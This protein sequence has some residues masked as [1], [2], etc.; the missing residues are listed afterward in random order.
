MPVTCDQRRRDRRLCGTAASE[1]HRHSDCFAL[2]HTCSTQ[3]TAF[4][5]AMWAVLTGS[6]EPLGHPRK[7]P[8]PSCDPR[9]HH[10]WKPSLAQL[11]GSASPAYSGSR[12][13][14]TTS[15]EPGQQ[16]SDGVMVT[17]GLRNPGASDAEQLASVPRSVGTVAALRQETRGSQRG[18]GWQVHDWSRRPQPEAN[19]GPLHGHWPQ[20]Q[21]ARALVPESAGWRLGSVIFP[22]T[23][24]RLGLGLRPSGLYTQCL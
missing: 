21:C 3:L 1:G 5:P 12:G 16:C 6:Q 17:S 23:R 18:W 7:E 24:F 2:G 8:A 10:L 22:E 14:G 20:Q 4:L 19:S 15:Q 11:V 9:A 13:R